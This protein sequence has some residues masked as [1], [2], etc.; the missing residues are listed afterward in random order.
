MKTA[1]INH[2]PASR[3]VASGARINYADFRPRFDGLADWLAA[4]RELVIIQWVA[5]AQEH[6][7]LRAKT[8][9]SLV[10]HV[11]Q[12]FDDL[13]DG[14]RQMPP[15]GILP[16]S[17]ADHHARE[18][19]R[20]CWEHRCGLEEMLEELSFLRTL[21]TG[22]LAVFEAECAAP[23]A[24]AC[25]MARRT[26][27]RFLDDVASR[28]TR[29][30]V[31]RQTD[32]LAGSQ[33]EVQ[34]AKEHFERLAD[35]RLRLMRTLAH[36][37]RTM[38][39]AISAATELL[40]GGHEDEASQASTCATLRRNVRDMD[41][42]AGQLLSY[43]SVMDGHEPLRAT[44]LSPGRLLQEMTATFRPMAAQKGLEFKVEPYLDWHDVIVDESKVRQIAANLLGNAIK[45]TSAGWVGIGM[46]PPDGQHW[47]LTVEDTGCGMTSE[48]AA[49][50]FD[51]YYRVP[52]TAHLPGTGL[53]LAICKQLVERLQGHI[54]LHSTPG[55]GTR[56]EVRL[57]VLVRPS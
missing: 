26:V 24:S 41:D 9:Y 17:P 20:C 11:P 47:S 54:S 34:A 51:E 40:D 35:A 50:V 23:G 1:N 7:A 39:G 14:L 32:A 53:G 57:P 56:V 42:L 46:R 36:D 18:H 3:D 30:F 13:I 38:L 2:H 15:A 10:D 49:R 16:G 25:A 6:L 37:L 31:Q 19:A 29:E 52:A 55:R 28:S 44:L 27:H 5:M 22:H 8:G 12:L 48:E 21:L 33:R 45:Y 4:R 43:S